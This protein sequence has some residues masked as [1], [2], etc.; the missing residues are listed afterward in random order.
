MTNNNASS[1]DPDLAKFCFKA[2]K[3]QRIPQIPKTWMIDNTNQ[4]LKTGTGKQNII[5]EN[6][7]CS[8]P[9]TIF[10]KPVWISNE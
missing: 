2:S 4:I 6:R 10:L 7:K 8:K 3:K 5:S 1:V 9:Q